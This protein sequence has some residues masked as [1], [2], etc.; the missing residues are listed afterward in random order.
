VAL[1]TAA[2]ARVKVRPVAPPAE[3]WR[4]RTAAMVT[5]FARAAGVD[6][7]A[8]N[9]YSPV[10]AWEELPPAVFERRSALTGVRFDVDAQ[11][12]FLR[13][14]EPFLAEFELPRGFMW[15]NRTYGRV[16]ADVLYAMVR[17]GRPRRIIELGSGFSS[18]IIAAAARRNIAE[19]TDVAYTAYDPY[20]RDFIRAGVEPLTL[21]LDS[22]GNV[23]VETFE[24]LR[25]GDVLFV[26]TTHTVK[27]GSEVNHVILDVLP[28][29]AP[30]VVVHV[31]DVFLPC[32][33][34]KGFFEKRLFWS[35]QYLL[36]AFLSQNPNWEILLP[37]HFLARDRP[38]EVAKLVRSFQPQ[39]G[40]G[41][42]WIRRV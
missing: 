19:G 24:A 5:R 20:A 14:L 1:S 10:P 33:Y 36:Q 28:R 9:Y 38:A 22:A 32:E 2:K 15:D 12:A 37:L 42:F 39:V 31:H 35:E 26:D 40:P 21:R 23:P 18:L 4:A 25:D 30:G 13:G 17:S 11:L 41:A 7:V 3:R 34:P 8:R 27:L 6:M 16:E 29:L